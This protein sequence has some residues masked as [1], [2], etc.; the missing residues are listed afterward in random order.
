MVKYRGL[1]IGSI[2][3]VVFGLITP[4]VWIFMQDSVAMKPDLKGSATAV[5]AAAFVPA[6]IFYILWY[7][8]CVK[9]N[10][11]VGMKRP[12]FVIFFG[13][14]LVIS[15]ALVLGLGLT[16]FMKAALYAVI[17]LAAVLVGSL[18][19]YLVGKPA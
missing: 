4:I 3:N 7:L 2:I 1:I 18:V 17:A 12:S 6:L 8:K 5:F 10:E 16:L 9:A 13:I 14:G 11:T 19:S 15:A